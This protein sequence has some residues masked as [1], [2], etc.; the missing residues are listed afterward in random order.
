MVVAHLGLGAL[1]SFDLGSLEEVLD[2]GLGEDLE[3]EED[4]DLGEDLDLEEGLAAD[5]EDL[6][7]G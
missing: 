5:F 1:E 2:F 7:P 3:L 6:D 4:L